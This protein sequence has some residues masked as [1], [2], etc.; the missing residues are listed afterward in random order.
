[1]P[2][3]GGSEPLPSQCPGAQTR[4]NPSVRIYVCVTQDT[5]YD[6]GAQ[7]ALGSQAGNL[8]SEGERSGHPAPSLSACLR[9][10]G[11]EALQSMQDP[12]PPAGT[13]W[14]N[15]TC[16]TLPFV[17]ES[18]R[19]GRRVPQ[20]GRGPPSQ[21][22]ARGNREVYFVAHTADW[23]GIFRWTPAK[24]RPAIDTEEA[25]GPRR[26]DA[27]RSAG[28]AGRGGVGMADS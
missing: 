23:D 10:N 3:E 11:G 9:W 17:Q 5:E 15:L 20:S 27:L 2:G 25:R 18:L 21:P 24:R 22:Q 7:E 16:F 13:L 4:S 6:S 12:G 19:P 1:M 8:P 14:S 26:T 28:L